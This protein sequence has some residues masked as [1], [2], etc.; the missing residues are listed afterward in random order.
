[1]H[2]GRS[3]VRVV[4][5][6]RLVLAMTVAA[7]GAASAQVIHYL[8][9]DGSE[10][11][12]PQTEL[13]LLG[14]D[15]YGICALG[16]EL[17]N[18]TA[19]KITPGGTFT[20]IHDFFGSA[21][22]RFP[23]ALVDGGDGSLYGL[24]SPESVDG[25]LYPGFFFRMGPDG[26]QTTLRA[27]A[28]DQSEGILGP[29]FLMRGSDGNFYGTAWGGGQLASG[30]AFQLTPGGGYT[31]LHDFGPYGDTGGSNPNSLVEAGAGT[32]I[33][34][35]FGGG[36]EGYGTIFRISTAG[37]GFTVLHSFAETEGG[38]PGGGQTAPPIVFASDGKIYGTASQYG[39]SGAGAVWKI[40]TAGEFEVV[41]SLQPSM[42]GSL[43]YSGLVQANDG[44]LYGAASAGGWGGSGLLFQVTL[45]GTYTPYFLFHEGG[46]DGAAPYSAPVQGPD[47]ALYG[48]T[49]GGNFGVGV[50]Y[51]Q[52]LPPSVLSVQPSSG[53]AA[54]GAA[55]VITGTSF[56]SGASAQ[57][58]GVAAGA[59][60]YVSPTEIHTTAPALAAGTL[61]DVTVFDADPL[62]PYGNLPNG[63]FAD[64]LDVPQF[65]AFHAHVE[66]IFRRGIT[67]GIGGG[68]YGRDDAVR[69]DQM[70]V[71]LLKSEHGSDFVPAACGGVY[72]DVPCP[73][74]FADWIEQLGAEGIT[75]GC[76]DGSTYCPSAPVTR[77]QMSVFLL[78]TEHGGAYVPPACTGVFEDVPCTSAFAPWVE[79]LFH[80]GVTGGCSVSPALFCPT[81]FSTRGQMAVFLDKTFG[82]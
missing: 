50:I 35:T 48:A 12:Q 62:S 61:N 44:N 54:G 78:L 27:F 3:V 59:I 69:R 67:A 7:P 11:S 72:A 9:G 34:T 47:G 80:E 58:G 17:G 6:M 71:F 53:P 82:F 57:I 13:V 37:A 38:S 20:K 18:G 28:V 4:F 33:G 52:T 41:H 66:K 43:P 46:T 26:S 25:T 40:S 10:G 49:Y 5:S 14:G 19:F 30:T 32:L 55:L 64:F 31:K 21:E 81:S 56:V 15:F 29:A 42:D 68:S 63:Y 65:D 75:A 16:G 77:Q 39:S 23:L 8:A 76:G 36:D 79:Q 73:S 24:M 74:S 1:L 22:G 45:A 60:D 51:R 2:A 70:A